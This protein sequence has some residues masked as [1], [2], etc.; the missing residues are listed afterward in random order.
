M[1]AD[2]PLILPVRLGRFA[3]RVLRAFEANKG[4]V[5][6]GALAYSALLSLVPLVLVV[7][8]L[9]MKLLD[10]AFVISVVTERLAGVVLPA[11]AAPITR[12]VEAF[13]RAPEAGGW[14]GFG[15]LLF[16]STAGFRV[17]QDAL[18][19]I[20]RHR[21]LSHGR[22]ALWA[23][24]LL[25]LAFVAAVTGALALELFAMFRL[26]DDRLSETTLGIASFAGVAAM[27]A[28]AYQ[29]MPVGGV[30]RRLSI[31]GGL[32]A[33]LLWEAVQRVLLWYYQSLSLVNVIYGS[34]GGIVV[35]LLSL[36]AG[37]SIVLLGA[38]IIAELERSADARVPWYEEPP[39]S[40]PP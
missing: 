31:I 26:G 25:S 3:L 30:R 18:D 12:A 23:S 15:A 5:L 36:E 35:L 8:A 33:A 4:L 19:V 17:L 32:S 22:R 6:A 40:I 11:Q 39:R 21:R 1:D 2:L 37:A 16:F 7:V 38:Q 9:A 20:F 10:P 29:F 13:V 27:L 14:L 34:I 28:A 24:A